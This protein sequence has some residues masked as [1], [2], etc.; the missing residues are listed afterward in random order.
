MVE[1]PSPIV[2]SMLAPFHQPPPSSTPRQPPPSST[3]A[4]PRQPPPSSTPAIPRQPPTSSTSAIPRQPPTSFTSAIPRQPPT[5]ST[6]AKLLFNHTLAFRLR[7]EKAQKA[8]QK[9]A[10]AIIV[11]ANDS[12]GLPCQEQRVCDLTKKDKAVICKNAWLTDDI[13]NAA[14]GLL[15]LQYPHMW[16][17]KCCARSHF[18]LH[19]PN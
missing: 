2:P 3:P 6:P 1:Q 15:K 14:Q 9:N 12:H 5:S 8:R 19:H 17:S 10:T 13:V 18:V 11:E 4:I 16:F 7:Q